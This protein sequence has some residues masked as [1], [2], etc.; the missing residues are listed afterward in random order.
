MY[1][2]GTHGDRLGGDA[3]NGYV[4]DGDATNGDVVDGDATDGDVVDGDATNGDVVD[5]NVDGDS[6]DL[7]G[8]EKFLAVPRCP[9]YTPPSDALR[10]WIGA[11]RPES[12]FSVCPISG[13]S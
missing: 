6:I 1:E 2:E 4:V 9:S 11:S 13:G 8:R 5:G 10:T 3:T 12:E 7:T